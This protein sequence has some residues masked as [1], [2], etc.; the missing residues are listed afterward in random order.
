MLRI[1]PTSYFYNGV[2]GVNGRA[3]MCEERV[4]ERDENTPLMCSRAQ[5]QTCWGVMS[6]PNRLSSVPVEIQDP[7][8][9]S[10]QC[11]SLLTR[12]YGIMVLKVKLK[13]I[14]S[15][16]TYVSFWL[17]CVSALSC[18]DCVLCWSVG[19]ACKVVWIWTKWDERFN[20]WTSISDW[21][22][23]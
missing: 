7:F 18:N 14:N 9:Q 15:I 16:I 3:V 17:M 19:S 6:H 13:S 1:S 21:Y 23:Q 10:C 2:S 22:L 12:L 8:V 5:G 20:L 11:L 4:E